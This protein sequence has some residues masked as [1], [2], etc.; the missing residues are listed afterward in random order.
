VDH[1][2]TARTADEWAAV[3]SQQLKDGDRAAIDAE[4]KRLG[5]GALRREGAR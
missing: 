5:F 4:R 1:D 2:Q 3:A